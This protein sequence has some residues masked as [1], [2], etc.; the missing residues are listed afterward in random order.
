[1]CI[2]A[3]KSFM[4][5]I[6]IYSRLRGSLAFSVRN[7]ARIPLRSF[8]GVNAK[9]GGQTTIPHYMNFWRTLRL[10]KLLTQYMWKTS[11]VT[12]VGQKEKLI[13][14]PRKAIEK[15]SQAFVKPLIIFVFMCCYL[16]LGQGKWTKLAHK[17][18]LYFPTLQ[19]YSLWSNYTTALKFIHKMYNLISN[20]LKVTEHQY[21]YYRSQDIYYF[22]IRC[23]LCPLHP[24]CW[25]SHIYIYLY[26]FMIL[27]LLFVTYHV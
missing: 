11:R 25:P 8:S 20:I 26:F 7:W 13:N 1:M 4:E 21:S 6:H 5:L 10:F 23:S 15:E 2:I 24:F 3:A 22:M 18:W 16:W 27:V 19:L 9:R 14:K 17:F 12:A